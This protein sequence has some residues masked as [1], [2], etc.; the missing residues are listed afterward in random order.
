MADTLPENWRSG[1]CL[2]PAQKRLDSNGEGRIV[3]SDPTVEMADDSPDPSLL[4][5]CLG[6]LS[7][8]QTFIFMDKLSYSWTESCEEAEIDV[9]GRAPSARGTRSPSTPVGLATLPLDRGSISS[10]SF[11]FCPLS[12]EEEINRKCQTSKGV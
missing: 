1:H 9:A 4:P 3:E 12:T 5:R 11:Q 8:C 7:A 2:Y 6:Q 10:S